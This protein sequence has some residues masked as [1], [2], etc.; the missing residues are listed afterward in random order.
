MDRD[1]ED[2]ESDSAQGIGL[3]EL[4]RA[5]LTRVDEVL[6]DQRRLRLLLDA[7][8]TIS[9]DLSLDGVLERIVE[10]TAE[11]A[12]AKYV[13]L[14][15]L[16]AGPERRLRAFIT[17]GVDGVTRT[18]IGDLPTGHGLLGLIIDE[19]TPLRLHDI[20]KH[21]AS[22]GFPEHHP[23][24][25]SFLGVPV[26]SGEHVFGNLYLTEKQGG[27]DFSEQDETIVVALAAAA[28]VV[29]ENARL[30]EEAARREHWLQATAELSAS[31]A[32]GLKRE[33]ALQAMADRCRAIAQADVVAIAVA[34]AGTD[35]ALQIASGAPV[36]VGQAGPVLSAE[37]SL[38]GQVV[39][40]GKSLVVPDVRTHPGAAP[41][42]PGWP[43]IGPVIIV[44]MKAGEHVEGAMSLGWT[45]DRA[46]FFH[47]VDPRLP[48]RYAEQA[49]LA[50]QVARA[51]LDRER[52]A[53]FEDRDRIGRDLHDLVIQR[54]FAV[55]LSLENSSRMV[56]QP[57]VRQRVGD[58][59]DDIDE[60]IK[61]IR[62]SIFALS[63]A[64]QSRDLRVAVGDVVERAAKVLGFVPTLRFDGPVNSA[65]PDAVA[66]HLLAVLGEALTNVARHAAASHTS[67][68][69]SVGDD[70]VLTVA[71]DGRGLP[72]DATESG[73]RNLRDRASA[74]GGDCDLSSGEG[75]GTTL[76]WRVPCR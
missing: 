75:G 1:R 8:V 73:L 15:V 60:T 37:G 69:L 47:D 74:L 31:L 22:Y 10:V 24:M 9:A 49:A 13:A 55:G 61:E 56:D 64:D 39:H 52:L 29:I 42:P 4:L 33:D 26:R 46:A 27:S 41:L 35:L 70:V 17:H 71:D 67:V 30:Y 18:R 21:P 62:R 19:P 58:A 11:L 3:D 48:E 38:V 76:T 7:V 68:T 20:S 14:G 43:T 59:V 63:A 66:P 6:D 32:D 36:P 54:L 40:T 45:P 12:D 34:G 53:V 57:E 44:P 25:H 23:P 72:P 51:R 2:V 16:G 5:V 65:V 28:G 50:L